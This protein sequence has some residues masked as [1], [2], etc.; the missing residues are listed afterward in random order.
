MSAVYV[1]FPHHHMSNGVNGSSVSYSSCAGAI[2]SCVAAQPRQPRVELDRPSVFPAAS[3]GS[4]VENKV[5]SIHSV[6]G[7][8]LTSSAP[9]RELFSTPSTNVR[10]LPELPVGPVQRRVNDH[11][12][13]TGHN[14]AR[15]SSVEC[16]IT[17][18]RQ[19][20]LPCRLTKQTLASGDNSFSNSCNQFSS[21]GRIPHSNDRS[22]VNNWNSGCHVLPAAATDNGIQSCT[23]VVS[24][25]EDVQTRPRQSPVSAGHYATAVRPSPRSEFG[26][27]RRP[28]S[29]MS[30]TSRM[31][32]TP[33]PPPPPP[34]VRKPPLPDHI[35]SQM[36][37]GRTSQTTVD[38][39]PRNIC[40]DHQLTSA[41]VDGDVISFR[42]PTVAT[43]FG[44]DCARDCNAVT[45][46]SSKCFVP[47]AHSTDATNTNCNNTGNSA[48]PNTSAEALPVYRPKPQY[49][50]STTGLHSDTAEQ[51]G[52]GS[53]VGSFAQRLNQLNTF[54]ERPGQSLQP[55]VAANSTLCRLAAAERDIYPRGI[56][57]QSE[58]CLYQQDSAF[59][60]VAPCTA[61][62]VSK[63]GVLAKFNESRSL[64]SEESAVDE[65]T[66]L[67][68]PPE[69]DD[70]FNLPAP[71][72]TEA[73]YHCD[74]V[75][76]YGIDGWSVDE[77]S[78]WLDV[79]DLGEHCAAFRVK[80]IDGTRVRT[81]GRSELIDLGLTDVHDRMKFERALRKV[82]KN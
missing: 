64:Q 9:L 16:H 6:H 23:S 51:S 20:P 31:L 63:I 2:A 19:S 26:R 56:S 53:D 30:T 74:T 22:S 47:V 18:N 36:D 46:M 27:R 57:H 49:E 39:S 48:V 72:F 77:V 44:A 78:D 79:V 68:P 82:L 1:G 76:E 71:C 21:V 4:N 62:P 61:T 17:A 13:Y 58:S 38:T 28:G 67:P 52:V 34:P 5:A 73:T 40:S 11:G 12:P 8:R 14:T 80:N 43:N 24:Q 45:T 55:D 69:F 35:R 7:K 50:I 25:S 65:E 81:L 54:C 75:K 41:Q 15:R 37:S 66:L 60:H 32:P 33:P 3:T 29:A 59:T 10:Q 42:Q 70:C